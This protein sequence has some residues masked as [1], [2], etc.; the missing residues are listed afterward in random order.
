MVQYKAA[1][2]KH[3]QDRRLTLSVPDLKPLIT[4]QPGVMVFSVLAIVQ[5]PS[6]APIKRKNRGPRLN[7]E[8]VYRHNQ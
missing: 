6:K 4:G 2:Q 8:S 5:H 3:T 1:L 7:T